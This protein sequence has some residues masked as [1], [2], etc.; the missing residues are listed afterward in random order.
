MPDPVIESGAASTA[1]PSTTPITTPAP[2]SEGGF[3][4]ID[5]NDDTPVRGVPGYNEPVRYGDLYKRLQG[6][7]TRKTQ[8]V[9]KEKQRL[10]TEHQTRMGEV[11]AERKRLEQ[12]A[13]G[14]VSRQQ[15]QTSPINDPFIQ[16]L[17]SAQYV[18]GKLAGKLMGY[19]QQNGF[20]PIVK[21]FQDRDQITQGLYNEVLDLRKIVK[22]LSDSHSGQDHDNR[23]NQLLATNGYPP[24]AAQ[25]A[26][27][28]YSAYEGDNLDEEFP[29][30]FENRWNQLQSI[31]RNVDRQ[32][33]DAA[34]RGQVR[35][36]G[37]GGT[38]TPGKSVGLK[39]NESAKQIADALWPIIATESD[40]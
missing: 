25:L 9:E 10:A 2:T 32:R 34:K 28:I 1:S 11:Q 14:L 36:P 4:G 27:E 13:A 20:A 23:I 6:D 8:A 7:H 26:K 31:F 16:E 18:D 22:G 33:V 5:I 24:E 40:T 17:S 30:I 29:A 3:S 38:G 21:A 35:L 15:S 37:K 19:I 12:I 39:G